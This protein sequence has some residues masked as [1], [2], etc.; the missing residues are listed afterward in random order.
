MPT[1]AQIQEQVELEREQLRQ[2]LQQL[3]SK[4]NKLE[5]KSYVYATLYGIRS[6]YTYQ[7]QVIILILSYVLSIQIVEKIKY[8]IIFKSLRNY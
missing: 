7:P 8:H 3:K 6:I 1:P 5:E 2:G 4:S